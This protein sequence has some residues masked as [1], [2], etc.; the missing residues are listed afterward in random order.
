[1]RA[2]NLQ[3]SFNPALQQVTFTGLTQ[4]QPEYVLA[5]VDITNGITIYQPNIT[6]LGGTFNGNVLTLTYNTN[7]AGFYA[8]DKLQIAYEG[9]AGPSNE[10]KETGGNLDSINASLMQAQTTDQPLY[11]VPTGDPQGDF[12]GLNPI[13]LAMSDNT[14]VAMNIRLLNPVNTDINNSTIISDAPAP[15]VISGASGASQV[16]DTRG[17]SSLAISTPTGVTATIL[18]SNDNLSYLAITGFNN[19]G[20]SVN[21]L[22]AAASYTFACTTRYVKITLT[23]AGA[24]TAYLRSAATPINTTQVNLATVGASTVVQAGVTGMLAVGGNI[25]S[26]V[27]PTANPILVGGIDTSGLTRRI[28]TDTNGG[29]LISG[30]DQLGST[31]RIL[32]DYAGSLL[33][34]MAPGTPAGSSVV[35]LLQQISGKLSVIADILYD[36]PQKNAQANGIVNAQNPFG[37]S[38]EPDNR[39]ADYFA[40]QTLLINTT[41]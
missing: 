40:A 37:T 9:Y 31:H 24:V 29:L 33:A 17:Y 10:S 16:I 27:A 4:I 6:A 25:G 22:A 3:Y 7:V 2:I 32:T 26:G 28:Q 13:E 11:F 18:G 1:M 34:Q 14:G 5:I 12:A 23:A 30:F 20:T 35:E 21:T 36:T 39:L 38:D 19:S 41:M 15:I 8:T